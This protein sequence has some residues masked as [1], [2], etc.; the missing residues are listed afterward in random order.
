MI[1]TTESTPPPTDLTWEDALANLHYLE[2]QLTEV[3]QIDLETLR[4]RMTSAK[5]DL[6]SRKSLRLYQM[7]KLLNQTRRL[8]REEGDI[9]VDFTGVKAVI[10]SAPKGTIDEDDY[11]STKHKLLNL[12]GKLTD[13][14]RK[15]QRLA[16]Q[17][18]E[19]QGAMGE[20]VD[21]S[22]LEEIDDYEFNMES[23]KKESSVLPEMP[24]L[25]P[26]LPSYNLF[27]H[28]PYSPN[29]SRPPS[30]MSVD[31]D[32]PYSVSPAPPGLLGESRERHKTRKV[33][34]TVDT[35]TDD[36]DLPHDA[37]LP[38]KSGGLKKKKDLASGRRRHVSSDIS[39]TESEDCYQVFQNNKMTPQQARE[40]AEEERK[41][42]AEDEAK[43]QQEVEEQIKREEEEEKVKQEE[44]AKKKKEEDEKKKA[45]MEAKQKAAAE[46]ALQLEA[47]KK[48]EEE[49]KKVELDA[50][51]KEEQA[52]KKA[53][54]EAK[55]KKEEEAKN[56]K[57][58]EEAQKKA[59]AEEKKKA[60]EEARQK[61]KEAEAKKKGEED[62]K[63]A[64]EEEKKHLKAEEEEKKKQKWQQKKEADA[65]A[66]LK[67]A[68][69]MEARKQEEKEAEARRKEAEALQIQEE[70]MI[71]AEEERIRLEEE[72][73]SMR[74]Q[75]KAMAESK[76]AKKVEEKAQT[77]EKNAVSG[78]KTPQK[79]DTSFGDEE[80]QSAQRPLSA[81]KKTPLQAEMEL[82]ASENAE[83]PP[84]RQKKVT[85]GKKTPQKTDDEIDTSQNIES[86]PSRQKKLSSGRKTPQS[87]EATL[88]TE[89]EAPPSRQRNKSSGKK[90]PQSPEVEEDRPSSMQSKG[91]KSPLQ[92]QETE[93][94]LLEE[95]KHQIK[96]KEDLFAAISDTTL[97][98]GKKMR[99]RRKLPTG[100]EYEDSEEEV[101]AKKQSYKS[102][103][104]SKERPQS[105]EEAQLMEVSTAEPKVPSRPGSRPKSG[106][107]GEQV[108]E[109]SDDIYTEE[110]ISY[111]EAMEVDSPPM[112]SVKSRTTSRER[113]RSLRQ[114]EDLSSFDTDEP[115]Q[116]TLK[117]RTASDERPKSAKSIDDESSIEE[118]KTV[119]SRTASRERP[120]TLRVMEDSSSI[121]IDEPPPP[122]RG[123]KSRTVS[124]ERAK[125]LQEQPNTQEPTRNVRSRT[126]SK[127]AAD[128]YKAEK[129]E[130]VYA[131][132]KKLGSRQDSGEYENRPPSRFSDF[133]SD[134]LDGELTWDEDED[135]MPSLAP[136][137]GI[138]GVQSR[139]ESKSR[140]RPASRGIPDLEHASD[141]QEYRA[142]T[143]SRPSSRA[144]LNTSREKPVEELYPDFDDEEFDLEQQQA[145]Q[146]RGAKTRTSSRERAPGTSRLQQSASSDRIQP[147]W[148]E[149]ESD[150]EIPPGRTRSRTSSADRTRV[151]GGGRDDLLAEDTGYD[152]I[153][154]GPSPGGYRNYRDEMELD[155]RQYVTEAGV[156]DTYY[157]PEDEDD[158]PPPAEPIFQGD[159]AGASGYQQSSRPASRGEV[160][161]Y[162]N[163]YLSPDGG[164]RAARSRTSSNEKPDMRDL[165]ARS[166]TTS[167]ERYQDMP[168]Q[169][170]MSAGSRSRTAS[171]NSRHAEELYSAEESLS[172]R[173]SS[174]ERRPRQNQKYRTAND[175]FED[176]SA[177]EALEFSSAYQEG[178]YASEVENDPSSKISKKVSFAESDQKFHLRPSPDVKTIPGTNLFGFA[179]SSTH[180]QP[181]NVPLP[182]PKNSEVSESAK[183]A[184]EELKQAEKERLEDS[185]SPKAFIKAMTKGVKG[186]PKPREERGGS[187]IDNVFRRGRS[188]SAQGSRSSSRQSSL[189]RAPKGGSS[190][191][192]H[193]TGSAENV[194]VSRRI[195][196]SYLNQFQNFH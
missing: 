164:K 194:D 25:A 109:T 159:Q 49:K 174:R 148:P 88:S 89:Q 137:A 7:R 58:E 79:L 15:Q 116:R 129:S 91:K 31:N 80:P 57:E 187:L 118:L 182:T 154:S 26:T 48:A 124:K 126:S 14:R 41:K 35:T 113:P 1:T 115:P 110:R 176:N 178:Q 108:M 107:R 60:V 128:H 55:R 59:E 149:E 82:D 163:R 66:K 105:K 102:R 146:A 70:K 8:C 147:L 67:E 145:Q 77:K 22:K 20:L 192:D 152:S 9:M 84:S 86:A 68:E 117:S 150:S 134:N 51:R 193:S 172:S 175:E 144:N 46:K 166:R 61:K 98:S 99:Q 114:M 52:K 162:D 92:Q 153:P 81:A 34:V 42:V 43:L 196:N 100:D 37:Y 62:A 186:Q 94:D 53:E 195:G 3:V 160:Q 2:K 17:V 71:Q 103:T 181:P 131:K 72:A 69:E 139:P 120:K 136:M 167:G 158:E 142:G 85:S 75:T 169:E 93:P 190:R 21:M 28:A 19:L 188:S 112:K 183:L 189:D 47:K 138:S 140:S 130:D 44:L 83:A 97:K 90:T 50:K 10:E 135:E 13:I 23:F 123:A 168:E 185:T 122:V 12:G 64:E 56:K 155:T 104:A 191:S 106:A 74:E 156:T 63:K 38:Q 170:Y 33:T 161:Q 133:M 6:V 32:R 179:P 40:K 78:E 87:P 24:R 127:E 29:N 30:A 95:E 184:L 141:D 111:E 180:E 4:Y 45:V 65:A 73:K 143:R 173:T 177:H 132:P 121:E 76:K 157:D 36:E 171:R 5:I 101:P 39:D 125:N 16:G 11:C 54:N 165:P 27:N 18:E 151:V 96:S 119:K